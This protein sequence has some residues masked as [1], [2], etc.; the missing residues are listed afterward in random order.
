MNFNIIVW[1]FQGCGHLGFDRFLKDYCADFRPYIFLL[2]ETRIS[3]FQ[4]DDTMKIK[5]QF[6]H[7]IEAKV[8]ASE[9]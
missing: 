1:N 6:S 3:G 2:L 8:F 5:F 7:R 9:I 4:A